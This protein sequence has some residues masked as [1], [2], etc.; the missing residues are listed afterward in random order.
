MGTS[1][2][3]QTSSPTVLYLV[4]D[5]AMLL[6]ALAAFLS[7]H[8]HSPITFSNVDDFC[9]HVS[10]EDVGC[11]ISDLR[12]QPID[13]FALQE[14]LNEKGSHL[15]LVMLTGYADVQ[16]A[17]KLM[18]SGAFTVLEKPVEM[19]GL[20]DVVRQAIDQSIQRSTHREVIRSA[21]RRLEKLTPEEL[22][23]LD[24]AAEGKPNKLIS[25][26]L[27]LSNRTVDRRR[28]SALQK[29]AADSVSEFAVVRAMAK[30]PGN[31]L[32]PNE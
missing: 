27:S 15:S 24:C 5:D 16:A 10:P 12:M 13:G 3:H 30:D 31:V 23:V 18:E 11:V 14:R 29:I 22:A 1:A 28:Q 32:P 25:E 19:D 9:Q 21:R 4:D 17:V 20:V 8:G 2:N 26:E 7:D 6:Q